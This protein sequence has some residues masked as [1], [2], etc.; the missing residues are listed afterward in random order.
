MTDADDIERERFEQKMRVWSAILEYGPQTRF[1]SLLY[2]ASEVGLFR[3]LFFKA[4]SPFIP[5]VARARTLERKMTRIR[6]VC[7][8][9]LV[10]NEAFFAPVFV[11]VVANLKPRTM[12]GFK[13]QSRC[14]S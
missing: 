3:S 7:I 14:Q 11:I 10:N 1:G 2:F 9:M 13:L 6:D 12:Q 4:L 5:R 8:D